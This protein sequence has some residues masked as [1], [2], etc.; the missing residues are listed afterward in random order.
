MFSWFSFAHVLRSQFWKI[1]PMEHILARLESDSRP[2]CRRLVG[3]IFNSFLPVNQP[4]AVWCE[5]CVALL[6]MSH[7]AARRFYQYAHEHTACT[8]IGMR[9]P[10]PTPRCAPRTLYPLP[11]SCQA[12]TPPGPALHPS[13]SSGSL[14]APRARLVRSA[15]CAMTENMRYTHTSAVLNEVP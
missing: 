15:V 8:N 1:C 5:R 2:V 4:E 10:G 7:A 12:P 9:S 6:Q 13:A 11:L 3:L 14:P